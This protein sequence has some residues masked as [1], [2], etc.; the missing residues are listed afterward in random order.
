MR[1][2]AESSLANASN[3]EVTFTSFG[4]ECLMERPATLFRTSGYD[5]SLFLFTPG[6]KHAG[7]LILHASYRRVW[8][9]QPYEGVKKA[10]L[11][12]R[13]ERGPACGRGGGSGGD[14]I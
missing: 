14:R 13:A 1:A 7:S 12:R 2:V 6:L 9:W 11:W 3:L 10:S 5:F 4:S 8:F